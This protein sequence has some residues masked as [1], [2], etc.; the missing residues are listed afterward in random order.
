LKAETGVRISSTRTTLLAS[1][2]GA[3]EYYDFI[4]YGIFAGEIARAIFPATSP[5]ISL[6]ASFGTFAVGY[7]ARPIGGIVLSHFGDRFG[8]RRVFVV[9]LLAMSGAT[10]GM[11]LVPSYVAWGLAAP[12]SMVLLR[13]IQGFCLGG[14]LPGAI[15]YVVETAPRRASFVSGFVF[16]CV[17]G[18][19]VTATLLSLA[20]QA[21]LTAEQV[22]AYGWRIPFWIGGALGLLGFW[23]RRSLEESPEFERVRQQASRRPFTE[24]MRSHPRHAL[25]GICLVAT[26]GA[27]NG[28]LFAYMPAYLKT[29]L[30]LDPRTAMV[31]QNLALIAHTLALLATAWLGTKFPPRRLLRVGAL[32]FLVFAY[33]WYAVIASGEVDIRL[34]L[35]VGG[36][37]AGLF[38]GSFAFLIADLFPTRIRFSGVALTLNVGMTCFSG[39]APLVGTWLIRETGLLAAPGIYLSFAA[40]IAFVATFFAKRFGGHIALGIEADPVPRHAASATNS[41]TSFQRPI[42]D[43]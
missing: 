5:L 12:V 35:I 25:V 9:S 18:G 4:I 43:P 11:G 37:A 33:S 32:V 6:M 23:V 17:M 26:T 29:V 24:L 19:V 7:L 10:F 15:T 36:I 27:F 28:L 30:Q 2:G 13:L 16:F 42:T 20:V 31:A 41:G 39:L 38:N 14:E 40:L 1:L 3:L 21:A 34:P 8:R 22:A